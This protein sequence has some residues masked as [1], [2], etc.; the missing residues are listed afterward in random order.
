MK[1][2]HAIKSELAVL[3]KKPRS[4]TGSLKDK[5]INNRP[6]IQATH[7]TD[8]VEACVYHLGFSTDK[9]GNP[10][11]G[12][13]V[14]MMWDESGLYVFAELE[15][16]VLIAQNQKDQQM[17]Y[18]YGDVFEL[19]V[20][21]LNEPYK[22]EMYATPS[23]NKSTLFFPTWPT[24]MSAQ[25]C[26]HNHNFDRLNIAVQKNA[27]GWNAQL[28][29]PVEQLTSFGAGWGPGSE[30]TVFCGRYNCNDNSLNNPE[31]SMVPPLSNTDYHLTA[32]YA[33]LEFLDN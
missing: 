32:E 19:F 22:W 4:M 29:V 23:G 26:L 17:H 3:E 13:K 1:T 24:L 25:E 21:P 5:P 14:R 2:A 20:K 31:L 6:V 30:W 8:P 18:L 7:H 15:D 10:T 33:A 28:F 12:G 11:E 27:M 9:A 16:S